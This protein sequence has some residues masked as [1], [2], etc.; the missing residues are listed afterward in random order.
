MF[1]RQ[2]VIYHRDHRQEVVIHIRHPRGRWQATALP[3]QQP[4][5]GTC[6]RSGW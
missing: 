5:Y 4:P 2:Q 6:Y 1:A 3:G